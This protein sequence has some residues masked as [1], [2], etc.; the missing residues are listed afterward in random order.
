MHLQQQG[1]NLVELLIVVAI[2]GI[3]ASIA[4]PAYQDYTISSRALEGLGLAESAK[5]AISTEVSSN[6]DLVAVAND[7]NSNTQH[8]GAQP[9]S[10]YVDSIVISN[11]SGVITIDYNHLQMGIANTADQLTLSPN[12]RTATG[13]QSLQTALVTGDTGPLDWA[14]SSS[15]SNVALNRG[16]TF[17]TPA[18]PILSKYVPAECR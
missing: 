4:L 14:C 6:G 8:N 2:I 9:T 11:I 10:K 1:F 13:I 18:N 5:T 16:L 3:L 12:V 17:T 15:T 7:W